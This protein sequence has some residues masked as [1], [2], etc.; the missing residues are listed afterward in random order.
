MVFVEEII[1]AA[2]GAVTLIIS[3]SFTVIVTVID[4]D[5]IF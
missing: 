4:D 3:L 2:F 1:V 5:R